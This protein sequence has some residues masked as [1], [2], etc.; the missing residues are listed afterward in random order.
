M[1]ATLPAGTVCLLGTTRLLAHDVAALTRLF[2]TGL[3][4]TQKGSRAGRELLREHQSL[5]KLVDLFARLGEARD[6]ALH[7]RAEEAFARL[8]AQLAR[9]AQLT[10]RA[11]EFLSGRSRE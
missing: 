1:G 5:Q 6:A 7:N 3:I 9:T 2:A 11:G 4:F 10:A 8:D